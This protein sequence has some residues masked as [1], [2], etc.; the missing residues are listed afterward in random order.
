M[1]FD[2]FIMIYEQ[3]LKEEDKEFMFAPAFLCLEWNLMV[4]LE[5]IVNAHI[6]YVHW[7]AN[8]LVFCCKKQSRPDGAE[9]QS[10]VAYLCQPP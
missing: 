9:Q 4:R 1:G 2:V 10:R 7:D 3:F 8:W 5:N 6:W